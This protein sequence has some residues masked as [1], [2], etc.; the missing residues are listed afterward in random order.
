MSL[1]ARSANVR[2]TLRA[3]Q[4]QWELLGTSWTDEQ[5]ARIGEQFIEPVCSKLQNSESALQEMD[6]VL[7]RVHRECG[8]D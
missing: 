2:E 3:L 4:A 5:H 1:L 8:W 7:T 6:A